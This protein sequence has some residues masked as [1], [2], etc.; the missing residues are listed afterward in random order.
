M[1]GKDILKALTSSDAEALAK[2]K[3]KEIFEGK[4]RYIGTT[5]RELGYSP[6]AFLNPRYKKVSNVVS[7][8]MANQSDMEK[9]ADAAQ[10]GW[11]QAWTAK[12][13]F[14]ANTLSGFLDGI[15]SNDPRGLANM[16][17]GNTEKQYGNSLNKL[18]QN[19]REWV[20]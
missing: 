19:I 15:G 8:F 13:A 16:A 18:A 17:F 14:V 20:S 4:P 7:P 3:E 2:Q 1:D 9:A 6:T 11:D 12:K 10:E 5:G